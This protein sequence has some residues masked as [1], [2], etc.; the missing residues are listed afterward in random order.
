M[1]IEALL[2]LSQ[3]KERILPATSLHRTMVLLNNAIVQATA[4]RTPAFFSF[5]MPPRHGSG[6]RGN[7]KPFLNYLLDD[8]EVTK[9]LKPAALKKICSLDRHFRHVNSTFKKCGL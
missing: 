5:W 1:W 7:G 9:L 6:W 2:F 3:T 4:D 8:P